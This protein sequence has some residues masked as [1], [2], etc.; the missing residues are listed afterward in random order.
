M[1]QLGT[2]VL[3]LVTRH[4]RQWQAEIAALGVTRTA[5]TLYRLDRRVRELLGTGAV[6]Y[7][8]HTGDA[9]MDRLVRQIRL[10]RATVLLH[11]QRIR[12]LITQALALPS[13]GSLRDL[14]V[15]VGLSHQ[16]VNQLLIEYTRPGNPEMTKA[17]VSTVEGEDQ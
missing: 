15:L 6:D 16:R 3:V 2:P 17:R 12:G 4:G 7:Q 9:E 14:G 8:F 5:R 10:A 13:G 1:R 11:E